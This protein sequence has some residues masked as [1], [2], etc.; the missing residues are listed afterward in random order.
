[1][2]SLHERHIVGW[3]VNEPAGRGIKTPTYSAP[4]A[5]CVFSLLQP[6]TTGY[7]R[8]YIRVRARRYSIAAF[9]NYVQLDR[10]FASIY[11]VVAFLRALFFGFTIRCREKEWEREPVSGSTC[12]VRLGSNVCSRAFNLPCLCNGCSF[13]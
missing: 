11:E 9:R 8:V 3:V 13:I 2:S 1:M 7:K 6:C 5:R 4:H 10:F 12:I